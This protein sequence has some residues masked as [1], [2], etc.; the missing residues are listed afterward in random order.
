MSKLLVGWL[1]EKRHKLIGFWT[2][3]H[4]LTVSSVSLQN[5]SVSSTKAFNYLYLQ[6]LTLEKHGTVSLCVRPMLN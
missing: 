2:E 3:Q 5:S 4:Q 6:I 1:V